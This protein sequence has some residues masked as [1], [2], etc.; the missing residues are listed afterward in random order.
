MQKLLHNYFPRYELKTV[1]ELKEN[2]CYVS[3]NWESDVQNLSKSRVSYTFPEGREI[4]MDGLVRVKCPELLFKPELN[5]YACNSIHAITYD[6]VIK[7]DLYYR[8]D[9]FKNLILS[10]G[11]TMYQGIAD[12]LKSEL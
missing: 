7:S 4:Y 6:S 9:L 3:Q 10:G 2:F 5:G 11:S 12:R 1:C 8:K